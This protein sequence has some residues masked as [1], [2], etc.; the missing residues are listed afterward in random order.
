MGVKMSRLKN[1]KFVIHDVKRGQW[2]TNKRE[3]IMRSVA[4][5]DGKQV[6]IYLE[7]EPGS[8][9]KDSAKASI[10]NL[11]GFMAIPHRP[12]GDK[13]YRADP[14][15]VSVNNGDVMLLRG[16]WN[17]DFIEEHRFFPFSKYKDQVDASSGAYTK[18]LTGKV[19]M[20]I[21]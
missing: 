12:T 10:S 13:A 5:A 18:L 3:E 14:Y 21:G 19:A 1:G 16:D 4:E 11:A 15:S 9:G 2:A 8:G 7:Q 6:I 20:A 17:F